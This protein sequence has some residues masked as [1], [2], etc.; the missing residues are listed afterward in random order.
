M[1]EYL[2]EVSVNFRV[3]AYDPEHAQELVTD[4]LEESDE[5]SSYQVLEVF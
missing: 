3:K 4:I 1:D 2:V 5:V